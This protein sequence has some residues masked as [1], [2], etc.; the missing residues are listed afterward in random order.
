MTRL[1][2]ADG[3][4]TVT[5]QPVVTTEIFKRASLNAQYV[6]QWSRCATIAEEHTRCHSC[7]LRTANWGYNSHTLTKIGQEDCKNVTWSEKSWFLLWR[8]NGRVRIWRK[9]HKSCGSMDSSCLSTVQAAGGV[10]VW[11]IFS[12]HTLGLLVPIEHNLNPST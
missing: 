7:Q 4:A 11:R 3:K 9:Q 1:D 8:S 10:M 2:R 12:W 6:E 5:Q